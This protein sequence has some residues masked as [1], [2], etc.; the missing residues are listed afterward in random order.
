MATITAIEQQERRQR[1]NVFLDGEFA[2]ALSLELLGQRGLCVGDSLTADEGQA[3]Q[4]EELRQRIADSAWRLLAYRPRSR[5]ELRQR[6]L[7]KGHPA[8]AVDAGLQRLSDLGYLDDEEFARSLVEA[9][10]SGG[11]ARGRVALRGE[12]R[13]KGIADETS[14]AA[15]TGLDELAGA[16]RA[17]EK[18]LRSLHAVDYAEFRGRLA[19]FLQRRGFSYDAIKATIETLWRERGDVLPDDAD[20][21]PDD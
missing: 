9:R 17:A 6:L 2:F 4:G 15:L 20:P 16:R 13:R 14:D 5:N 11:S 19:P 3:L 21:F 8:E 12:L 10:Q 18:R 1:A 7:R